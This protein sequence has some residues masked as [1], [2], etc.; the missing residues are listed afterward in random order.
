MEGFLTRKKG[1]N[2]EKRG[3]P[4]EAR[5]VRRG[6]FFGEGG[7]KGKN[8][9]KHMGKTEIHFAGGQNTLKGRKKSKFW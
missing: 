7:W 1:R 6:V 4:E 5:Q 8:R 3:Y 9:S 2:G